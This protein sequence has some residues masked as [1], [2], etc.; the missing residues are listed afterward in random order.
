MLGPDPVLGNQTAISPRHPRFH[1]GLTDNVTR[2]IK[3]QAG[4]G[5]QNDELSHIAESGRA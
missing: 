5:N 4:L 3:T 1:V 2:L